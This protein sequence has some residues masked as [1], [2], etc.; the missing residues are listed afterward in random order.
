MKKHLWLL[1][2]ALLLAILLLSGCSQNATSQQP[3]AGTGT[4]T[5]SPVATADEPLSG[6]VVD[7]MRTVK[8]EAFKYAFKPEKI[9]VKKGEMVHLLVTATD[10]EHG[11][12]LPDFKI[13]VKLP[14]QK[15][16]MIVF[17]PTKTGTF[18][19]FCSVY[20]GSGHKEMKGTL[21]VKE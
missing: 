12:A 15:E 6:E 11:I 10:V 7:G 19:F 1:I 16:Q 9:V 4:E 3:T 8:V 2:C 13:D 14:P 5:A 20:C 18:T 17:T 21:I